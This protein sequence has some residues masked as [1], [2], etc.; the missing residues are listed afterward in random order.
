[1]E[2]WHDTIDAF[3]SP[4]EVRE[5]MPVGLWIGTWPVEMGQYVFVRWKV[6]HL[7]GSI[8]GGEVQAFWQYNDYSRGNSY[9]LA[10]IGPFRAGDE[11]EYIVL[12]TSKDGPENGKRFAFTVAGR[13]EEAPTQGDAL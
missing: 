6:T 3:R 2:I 9:W 11:V 8:E 10:T 12:G 1:M 5:G 13:E 7:D 4:S